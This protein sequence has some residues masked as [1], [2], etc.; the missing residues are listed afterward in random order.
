MIGKKEAVEEGSCG[1]R[2]ASYAYILI[3][4]NVH[5]HALTGELKLGSS[6]WDQ[7]ES[8]LSLPASMSLDE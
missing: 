2:C 4:V 8:C 3:Q 5:L 1:K 7:S 6:S